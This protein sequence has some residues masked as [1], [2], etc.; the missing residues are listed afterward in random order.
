M[1]I[2]ALI[3]AKQNSKGLKNKN[4]KIFNGQ[5]LISRTI[6]QA[7]AYKKFDKIIVSTD[8]K[9]IIK[10]AKNLGVEAPFVR[11]SY[12]C[13]DKSNEWLVWQHALKFLK[14]KLNYFPDI[15]VILPVTAPLR[16]MTDI[17]N[18]ISLFCK[19]SFDSLISITN[20][21]KNPFFNMVKIKGKH[22]YKIFKSK[23]FIRRQDAPKIFAV[24]TV[25]YIVK[26]NFLSKNNSIWKGNIIPFFVKPENAIDI[27][28]KLDFKFAEYIH[29]FKK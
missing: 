14:K 24:S 3:C 15:L 25:I 23:N 22:A 9:K 20:S 8:S 18:S 5:P 26:S 4:I 28:T 19:N 1:K 2:A 12:L 13:R 21:S 10:I 7:I 6:K 16:E 27:D 11:P 17:K 29:K